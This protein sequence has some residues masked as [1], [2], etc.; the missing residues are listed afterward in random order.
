MCVWF[1]ASTRSVRVALALSLLLSSSP[2]ARAEDP[3][4]TT[5]RLPTA[6]VTAVR[7]EELPEDPSSF[8]TV[9]EAEAYEGESKTVAGLLEESVGVQ[10][11]RFG[12][13]GQPSEISIRGSTGQQVVI[14][15]DGVRLNTA[16]SGTVDLSTIPLAIV[17]RIEV[18]RGGGGTRAGS[19]A[20]GGVVNVVTRRGTGKPRTSAAVTGGSFG[21]WQGSLSHSDRAGPVDYGASY[22]G[23]T[24]DGD[25]DFQSVEERGSG[26]DVPSRE[27]ERI[28]N[29]SESHAFLLQ[30]AGDL[31]PGLRLRATDQLFFVSRGQPGPDTT[32]NA[33]N[34]GQ[35]DTARERRTRN[36][37]SLRLDADGWD[38]LPD[39]V[40]VESTLSYLYERSRFREP[41]PDAG[42]PIETRQ[43]NRSAGLRNTATVERE[44]FGVE[45]VASLAF[46]VRY[47][48]LSSNEEGFHRRYTTGVT[49]GDELGFWSSRVQVVPSLRWDYT[50]DFGSEW[51]PHLG[52]IFTPLLWLRFKGN[53]E[54]SYRA[55]DF[56]E[57][58]FPDKGFIRGNPNLR[59]EEAWNADVGFELGFERV[60]YVE[61]LRLQA[62]WFYQ[63]ID[64]SIVFQRIS[65]TTVAPTNTNDATVEG[66]ELA[67]SFELFDWVEFSANWTHQDADLDRPQLPGIPGLFPPIAQSPGTALPGRADDEYLLRLRVG[68]ESGLFKLIGERRHTSKVHLSFSN[69]PTL[70]AR[71]VYDVSGVVDVAQL[72][73]L[74]SRWFPKKVLVSVTAT[75]VGD[76]SVRDSLGFPQPGRAL[77]FGLEGQW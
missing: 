15:L 33:P 60:G 77:S 34:G 28:N 23:F 21:T 57:L 8:A 64:N 69:E 13:P 3:P 46:D 17:D 14:L 51:I 10:V 47:D 67:G 48:S 25:W 76:E 37:A 75:N 19:G 39:D 62:A 44:T 40:R 20:I 56:D 38:P 7:P 41:E 16:Q 5:R 4:S 71:T 53:V 42:P 58:F 9:I 74:D 36:V 49:A 61:N 31:A 65:P 72:W 55:P 18:S 29:D 63:D 50:D 2:A 26:I 24:T 52:L 11:R 43:K 68:P 70:D 66:I 54:R 1:G 59:P 30:G 22:T 27:L 35:S 73:R 45:H 32:P 6:R 12:G